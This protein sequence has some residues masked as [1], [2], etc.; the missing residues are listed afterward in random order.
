MKKYSDFIYNELPKIKIPHYINK[1]FSISYFG[2]QVRFHEQV[3][4]LLPINV[5]KYIDLVAGGNGTPYQLLKEGRV[6]DI[7]TNDLSYYSYITAKTVFGG[8]KYET[9]ELL[10]M[11]DIEVLNGYSTNNYNKFLPLHLS[12]YIDGF[13][14]SNSNNPIALAALGKTMMNELTFRG[15]GLCHTMMDGTKIVDYGIEQFIIS[16]YKRMREF[17]SFIVPNGKAHNYNANEFVQIY[18]GFKDAVVYAD[19]AWPFP[20]TPLDPGINPY[21]FSS[22]QLPSILKQTTT[23]MKLPWNNTEETHIYNDIKLWIETTLNKGAQLF[24]I[25]SQSTNYP[26]IEHLNEFIRKTFNVVNYKEHIAFSRLAKT[27]TF[28]EYWWVIKK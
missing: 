8:K 7:A 21:I 27:K 16:I 26:P 15:L 4:E 20:H 5:P 19:P 14:V 11:L 18:D 3:K 25:N 9:E 28:K 17:N 13:C 12:E 2:A 6:L 22:E 23:S 1:K 24:I 10:K